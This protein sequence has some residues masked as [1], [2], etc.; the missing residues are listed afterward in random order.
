[1]RLRRTRLLAEGVKKAMRRWERAHARLNAVTRKGHKAYQRAVS[2]W[3]A[4]RPGETPEEHGRRIQQRAGDVDQEI[5]NK[6]FAKRQAKIANASEEERR[7]REKLEKAEQA[8]EAKR[9]AK[10]LADAPIPD[11]SKQPPARSRTIDVMGLINARPK[12]AP[13]QPAETGPKP[14]IRKLVRSKR[15]PRPPQTPLS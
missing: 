8:R 6:V 14:R 1:M 4:R 13:V 10:A 9:R 3:E 15:R 5:Y 12:P 2:A 11:L 7:R